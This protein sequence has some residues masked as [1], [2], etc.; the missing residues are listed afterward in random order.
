M[1]VK[2]GINFS[3]A[4]G[5]LLYNEIGYNFNTKLELVENLFL[6]FNYEYR[7]RDT[8]GSEQKNKYFFMK[9]SYNF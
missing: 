6:D 1:Y 2:F 9:A 4:D 5:N 3:Q 8:N 7:Y